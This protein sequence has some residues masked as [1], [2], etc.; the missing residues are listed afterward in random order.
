MHI[1]RYLEDRSTG[2]FQDRKI[3]FIFVNFIS[4]ASKHT[5]DP[6]VLPGL[7]GIL[8]ILWRG[9]TSNSSSITVSICYIFFIPPQKQSKYRDRIRYANGVRRD[10]RHLRPNSIG[11]TKLFVDFHDV[12][13]S[14]RRDTFFFRYLWSAAF[15]RNGFEAEY[16]TI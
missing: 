2:T 6:Q 5:Y 4:Y 9:V 7:S 1:E 16:A 14:S 15:D 13:T 3:F 10:S 12:P 8:C 11:G